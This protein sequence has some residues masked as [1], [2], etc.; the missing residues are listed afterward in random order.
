MFS[1]Y[2]EFSVNN[3]RIVATLPLRTAVE[4]LLVNQ[5]PVQS[6]PGLLPNGDQHAFLLVPCDDKHPGVEGCDYSMIEA[7]ATA[8]VEPTIH[9]TPGTPGV[10]C[11]LRYGST[12]A[13]FTFH[14][15]L[16]VARSKPS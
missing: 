6:K 3:S 13:V 10:G 1:P 15:L 5:G 4:G 9:A 8:S 16:L 14:G 7:S 2:E 12:A 11:L